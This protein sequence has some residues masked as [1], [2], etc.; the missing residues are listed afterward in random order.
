MKDITPE[1]IKKQ[2]E[3]GIREETTIHWAYLFKK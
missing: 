3:K 1:G 2:I